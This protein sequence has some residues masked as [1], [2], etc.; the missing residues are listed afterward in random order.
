MNDK[1]RKAIQKNA[2]SI[3]L[4]ADID[5]LLMRVGNGVGRPLFH[6]KDPKEVLSDLINVRYPIYK[7]AH[8]HID[9]YDEPIEE[10]LNRVIETLYTYINAG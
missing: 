1:T 7:Q 6:N 4:K 2:I 5:V 10:T 3:F 9:T 8:L